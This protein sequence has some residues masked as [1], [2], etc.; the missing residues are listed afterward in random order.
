M[1][2]TWRSRKRA[3]GCRR[4]GHTG[5]PG[6]QFTCF[7]STKVQILT[8]EVLQ[9]GNLSLKSE[10]VKKKKNKLLKKIAPKKR[11]RKKN[12]ALKPIIHLHPHLCVCV[13]AAVSVCL[14]GV[15]VFLS[16]SVSVCECVCECVRARE[17]ASNPLT[18]CNNI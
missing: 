5:L 11:E 14:C 2:A 13:S 15:C 18:S 10:Q 3:E 12:L 4:W 9:A 16:V 7:T 8:S 17:G 6:T 1:W